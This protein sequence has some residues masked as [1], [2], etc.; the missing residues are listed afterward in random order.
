MAFKLFLHTVPNS[1]KGMKAIVRI[2][3]K[4]NSKIFGPNASIRPFL[5]FLLIFLIL[6][7]GHNIKSRNFTFS[8]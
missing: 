4:T 5:R 6:P 7:P 2:I 1:R 8:H 3:Q